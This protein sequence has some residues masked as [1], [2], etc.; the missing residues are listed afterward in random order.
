VQGSLRND[1]HEI[2]GVLNNNAQQARVRAANAEK[3]A[4]ELLAQIQPRE[5][6]KREREDIKR[7]LGHRFAGKFIEIRYTVGDG[8]SQRL[9][10]EIRDVL[11]S[12]TVGIGVNSPMPIPVEQFPDVFF[13]GVQLTVPTHSQEDLA[14][15]NTKQ[16][17]SER[18]DAKSE[19]DM[20]NALSQALKIQGKLEVPKPPLSVRFPASVSV[21]VG[22]KPIPPVK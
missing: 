19:V 16:G 18:K 6:S 8:E 22:S 13:F 4:A 20:A 1:A 9:S 15:P 21:F 7:A 3:Q 11:S 12:K 2:E 14:P 17:Q 10:L 5:L